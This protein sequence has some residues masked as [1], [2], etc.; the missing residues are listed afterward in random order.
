[1]PRVTGVRVVSSMACVGRRRWRRCRLS[2]MACVRMPCVGGMGRMGG[3]TVMDVSGVPG[4]VFRRAYVRGQHLAA[5]VV[6]ALDDA[7]PRRR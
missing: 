1:M 3:V 5:A 2:G 4:V 7:P 6:A